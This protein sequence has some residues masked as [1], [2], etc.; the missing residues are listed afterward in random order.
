MTAPSLEQRFAAAR[1]DPRL[2]VLEGFHAV[3]HA[4]RFGA[5][6]TA[7]V[8][9]D[10]AALERLA[11]RLAPDLAL[12][13]RRDAE[14]VDEAGFARLSPDRVDTGVI[15]IAERRIAG[16]A[17]IAAL[18]GKAPI[19]ALFSPTH[20]GN[21]GAA[22]RVSAAAGADAVITT[23]PHDPWSAAALRGSAG[24]H[25]AL[26]VLHTTE[27]PRIGRP[28]IAVAP[29]GEPLGP[30]AI[31]DDALLIFGSERRGLPDDVIAN[32]DAT[33]RI[34]MRDG[35]SSLN[36]ATAVAVALYAWRLGPRAG[37]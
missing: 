18:P 33:L 6:F 13:L 14:A 3:K 9:P 7:L 10:P 24:L 30:R 21:I 26:P 8:T 11:L 23:G 4:M 25:Y 32:A 35:V 12:R 37:G 2:A 27:I 17:E 34:P 22:I 5:V 29:D 1:H 19:V 20:P 31:P 16:V 15:G 36:L 28:R